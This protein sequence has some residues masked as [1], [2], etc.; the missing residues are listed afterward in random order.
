MYIKHGYPNEWDYPK[1]WNNYFTFTFVR[2]PISRFLSSYKYN[3]YLAQKNKNLTKDRK[4]VL[5][6]GLNGINKF[7]LYELDKTEE[8][9]WKPCVKWIDNF[10]YDFIGKLENFDNDIKIICNRLE[11][12][13]KKNF[14]NKS[15]IRFRPNLIFK[16]NIIKSISNMKLIYNYQNFLNKESIEILKNI[17][18]D[19]IK[20]FNY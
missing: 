19:D 12:S 8:R 3:L 18:Q 6:Y 14:E 9:F 11:I 2:N 15:K 7:V 20:R 13:Y 1:Y 10:D 17:Y 4:A 16:L 5:K